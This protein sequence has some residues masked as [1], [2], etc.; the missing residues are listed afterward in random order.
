MNLRWPTLPKLPKLPKFPRGRSSP[1]PRSRA[2]QARTGRTAEPMEYEEEQPTTRLSSAFVVVVLLH[3]VA[4]AGIYMFNSIKANRRSQE[5]LAG[6][7]KEKTVE[8]KPAPSIP[9]PALPVRTTAPASLVGGMRVH[10]VR[11]GDT[12]IKVAA[13]H[14]VSAAELAE[15]NGMKETSTLRTGTVLNLPA[16]RPAGAAD[17]RKKEFLAKQ[18]EEA[19]PKASAKALPKTYTVQKGDTLVGIVR[20]LGVSYEDLVKLNKI[21]DPKKLQINHVLKVPP[22]N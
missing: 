21:D 9:E 12:L 14:G 2:L 1:P 19:A 17:Q 3:V 22:K 11:A 7:E 13:L 5:V 4:V 16:A 8:K 20:K 6:P 15:A 10:H 18:S